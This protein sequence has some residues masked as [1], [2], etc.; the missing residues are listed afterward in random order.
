[1]KDMHPG[2]G[3]HANGWGYNSR[4]TFCSGWAGNCG[5]GGRGGSTWYLLCKDCHARYI[6]MKDDAKKKAVKSVSLPRV[7]TKKPGKPCNLLVITAIQ[8]MIQNA[9]FLLEI[10]RSCDSAP[11]TPQMKS[12]NS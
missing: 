9:K 5:D 11:P 2:C 12:L 3:K 6:V 10:S 1:M 8:G 4:G 7:K